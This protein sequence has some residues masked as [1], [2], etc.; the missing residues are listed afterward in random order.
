MANVSINVKNLKDYQVKVLKAHNE[1][2]N[3][4]SETN[5]QITIQPM[6]GAYKRVQE[7]V[8][9][10]VPSKERWNTLGK[11]AFEK[12]KLKATFLAKFFDFLESLG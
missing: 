10:G 7:M 3:F 5:V 11:E 1:L 6:E 12:T 8:A 2:R 9:M 4:E